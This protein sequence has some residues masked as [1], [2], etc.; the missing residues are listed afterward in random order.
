L[1]LARRVS[2]PLFALF[3]V[4][5]A[6][7]L[8]LRIDHDEDLDALRFRLAVE[9][10]DVAALR[11]HAPFYPVYIAAA[12]LVA[13]LGASSHG[14]LA[15]VSAAAGAALVVFTA[16]I[17]FEVFGRRAAWIAGALALASPFLWLSSEKLLSDVPGAAC[18]T[19][20]LWLLARA[21][22]VP[23]PEGVARL[24]TIALIV[25]GVGLGVRLSYFPFAIVAL[26]V[27]AREEGGLRAH[28]ARA[29]DLAVGVVPWLV[30][31]VI[32]AGSRPLLVAALG[33]GQ[34]HFTRWGGSALTV[35][36][37]MARLHGVVWGLW[38]NV[39]GGA[40]IDA[41]APRARWLGA[42][43]LV[44]LLIFAARRTSLAALR[45]HPELVLGALAYF[46]WAT[47]G[48]N[49]AYK[50]RHWLPLAP[51]LIV[52]LAAGAESLAARVRG[53]LAIPALLAAQWLVDGAALA[54]AHRAPS[55][56]AALVAFVAASNDPRPI[57]TLDLGPLLA[58]GAP[59]RRLL[60]PTAIAD[61]PPAGAWITGEALSAEASRQ[62]A[63]RGLE[64]RRIF[65]R[66][67]SRYVDSLWSDLALWAIE[68][69]QPTKFE[70]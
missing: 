41:D 7:R 51:L 61:L 26:L 13:W 65:A 53:G 52:A 32:L 9:R 18:T 3:A 56:A 11:P 16:L 25:L 55:P 15:I 8:A 66:P 29:R 12:K 5:L 34:G 50:P 22:R 23:G 6:A 40:W 20:A 49:T 1:N 57:V 47:L 45:R 38:A 70:R 28:V 46:V 58:D 43:L 37:P 44:L 39:L 4:A 36:S 68:P 30:P 62:L 69:Q 31:L 2:A 19:A 54:D 17:A 35:T 42:P 10:F 59:R 24:R 60:D 33:Q 48:Q 64:A 63:A 14:A 67:R 27:I 21:R